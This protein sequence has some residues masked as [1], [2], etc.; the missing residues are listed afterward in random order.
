MQYGEVLSKAW[1]IIW[2][3]KVLWIFGILASLGTGGGGGGGGGGGSGYSG[4][5]ETFPQFEQ[6]ANQVENWVSQNWWVIGVIIMAVVLLVLVMIV[7]STFGRIGLARG[8]WQVDEG[9]TSLSFGE[10]FAASSPYFW[11]VILLAILIFVMWLA[12]MLVLIFPV[13]ITAGLAMICLLPVFC[14]LVPIS[15]MVGI[16]V[17]QAVVAIVGEDLGVMD[18]LKRGW[19]VFRA[20]IGEMLIMGLVL[21]IGGVIAQ[22]FIALPFIFTV[23][24]LIGSVII[25]NEG[26]MRTGLTATIVLVCLYAPVALILGGIV[27]S[28]LGTA[29]ALTFRRLTGKSELAVVPTPYEVI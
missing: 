24:P 22:L 20:H 28:Y 11:R 16:V 23:I 21:G 10:L 27:Q 12:L 2:K 7:L 19:E 5:N 13:I 14:L 8:A 15:W 3:H 29:W 4:G 26:A 1:K 17:E 9:K 25:Q 6:F 18:G